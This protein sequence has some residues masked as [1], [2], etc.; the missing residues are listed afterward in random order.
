MIEPLDRGPA[1]RVVMKVVARIVRS[2]HTRNS[3]CA[4]TLLLRLKRVSRM[5]ANIPFIRANLWP[6]SFTDLPRGLYAHAIL[7]VYE[8]KRIE[9]L[10]D[11]FI[12][13]YE[14]SAERYA[15]VR[16]SLGEPDPFRLRHRNAL[17]AV[18]AEVVQGR[19]DRKTAAAHIAS[20]A[21]AH[22][23]ESDRAA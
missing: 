18:V 19:M 16:Q 21:T 4:D 15:A 11:V 22:L 5:A 12:W 23:E 3:S 2:G 9:L 7:G 6:L 10:R 8:L 17:R 13:S 1:E 14:R 20:W